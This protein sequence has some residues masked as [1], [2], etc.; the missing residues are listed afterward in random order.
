[1]MLTYVL[2]QIMLLIL[3]GSR[4][5]ISAQKNTL[6]TINENFVLFLLTLAWMMLIIISQVKDPQESLK[7]YNEYGNVFQIVLYVCIFGNFFR[8]IFNICNQSRKKYVAKLRRVASR[9]AKYDKLMNNEAG[10]R[11]CNCNCF[12]CSQFGITSGIERHE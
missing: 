1:M 6:E 7:L 2:C 5:H 10:H 12:T 11:Q 3:A 8:I 9:A 4:P